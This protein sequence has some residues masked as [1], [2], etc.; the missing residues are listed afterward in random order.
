MKKF[1]IDLKASGK[2]QR[3]KAVKYLRGKGYSIK[4]RKDEC[5]NLNIKYLTNDLGGYEGDKDFDFEY[6]QSDEA[7][8]PTLILSRDWDKLI[9][10]IEE[11]LTVR[12]LKDIFSFPPYIP[13]MPKCNAPKPKFKIGDVVKWSGEGSIIGVIKKPCIHHDNSWVIVETHTS[14]HESNLTL[15]TQEEINKYLI[16]QCNK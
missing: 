9:K 2:G 7:R 5:P 10:I 16:E 1:S 13:P 8:E 12:R 4:K 15:A 14:C 6:D 11:D 3:K